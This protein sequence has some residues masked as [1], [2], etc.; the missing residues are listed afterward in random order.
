M[1]IKHIPF[2]ARQSKWTVSLALFLLMLLVW[3]LDYLTG[4]ELSSAILYLVPIG[5]A[6]WWLGRTPGILA[7]LLGTVLWLVTDLTTCAIS[8]RSV[9]VQQ[10]K[11]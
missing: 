3:A 8:S 7:S 1:N 11:C 6:A 2:I 10:T 9:Q 5:I 4:P